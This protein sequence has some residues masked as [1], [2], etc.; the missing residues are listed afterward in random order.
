M[1]ERDVRQDLTISH[2][3]ENVLVLKLNRL[4]THEMWMQ[5]QELQICASH[6][7]R[8][9][10]G[11]GSPTDVLAWGKVCSLIASEHVC[12]SI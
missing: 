11:P 9:A 2:T 6:L 8:G 1:Q 10:E 12:L 3:N 7:Q 5:K 4:P